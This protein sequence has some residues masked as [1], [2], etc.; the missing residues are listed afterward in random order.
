[1]K[2]D[3]LI[4]VLSTT[5]PPKPPMSLQT[6]ALLLAVLFGAVTGVI[7]GYR[8]DIFAGYADLPF[9]FS[10]KTAFFV[11]L[12]LSSLYGL[13][14]QATPVKPGERPLS[15]V[16]ITLVL[17]LCGVL[18]ETAVKPPRD[19]LA[20]LVAMNVEVCIL[21]VTIYS[22]IGAVAMVALLR[23]Y[24]PADPEKAAAWAGMSA[25][26]AGALGYSLHCTSDS[27]FFI[28]AAYG[29]PTLLVTSLT[30]LIAPRFLKW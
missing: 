25:A 7:L 8:P 21:M 16:V 28:L 30:G 9:S 22:A 2:T 6:A 23:R 4:N 11:M 12:L 26:A 10:L 27:P 19:V 18:I 20:D 3:E 24:A 13:R 5:Q 15:L 29:G 1:M 14:Y 17:L